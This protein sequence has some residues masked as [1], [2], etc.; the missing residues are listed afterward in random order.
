MKYICTTDF[1]NPQGNPIV[2]GDG[3]K[4]LLVGGK[5]CKAHIHKGAVFNIG[6]ATEY[7][8]LSPSEKELVAHLVVSG[9][10]AEASEATVK[11]INAEV[12]ADN[13]LAES[14]AKAA[15]AAEEPSI[16]EVLAALPAMIAAAVNA[17]K[18]AS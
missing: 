14:D 8:Q 1:P 15:K 7:A 3:Q 5:E 12:E 18:G 16:S 10:I 4:H 9:K 2:L 11:R 17:K 13:K 6:S